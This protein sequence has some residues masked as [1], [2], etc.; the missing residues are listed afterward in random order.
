MDGK[1]EKRMDEC[2]IGGMMDGQMKSRDSWI[3]KADV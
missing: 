2:W 3:S 1:A